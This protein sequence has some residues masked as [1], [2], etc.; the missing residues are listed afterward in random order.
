ML[1]SRRLLLAAAAE[2]VAAILSQHSS[3]ER[4]CVCVRERE[5][6]RASVLEKEG[7]CMCVLA[8]E[9]KK[10]LNVQTLRK[11]DKSLSDV[12]NQLGA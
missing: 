3:N 4:E 11:F 7:V 6:E 10:C 5:R 12:W 8:R 2:G 1:R 9:K